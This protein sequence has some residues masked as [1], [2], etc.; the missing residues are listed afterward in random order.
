MESRRKGS[1]LIQK[2]RESRGEDTEFNFWDDTFEETM[3]HPGRMSNKWTDEKI[4]LQF[5]GGH[6]VLTGARANYLPR[7]PDLLQ[8]KRTEGVRAPHRARPAPWA[9]ATATV[10]VHVSWRQRK[11]T[12]WD[13]EWCL[14]KTALFPFRFLTLG[15]GFWS[16]SAGKAD[17]IIIS[18]SLELLQTIAFRHCFCGFSFLSD[19]GKVSTME[20]ILWRILCSW[21]KFPP[22]C[23]AGKS[24]W[25]KGPQPSLPKNT[26]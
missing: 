2:R 1:L 19:G 23:S 15:G 16:N 13:T 25:A 18:Y 20:I 12:S 10:Q 21:P 9:G 26:K 24:G 7:F 4:D 8:R 14:R 17:L 11:W 22:K 3:R 6:L 5:R